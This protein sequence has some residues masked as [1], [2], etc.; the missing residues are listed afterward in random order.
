MQDRARCARKWDL[1]TE[2]IS[3]AEI[4][5]LFAA[6]TNTVPNVF[7]M[8][9]WIYSNPKLLGE[10]RSEVQGIVRREGEEGSEK[11]V[12]SIGALREKCPLLAASF[13]ETLRLVKTG[14]S[15]RTILEDTMLGDQYLLKKGAIVQI[16]TGVLQSDK[17]TWGED[18][19]VFN[20]YRWLES[21]GKAGKEV[22]EE[23]KLQTQA[24]LPFG[25]GKNLCP[26]RH[27]AFNEISAFVAMVVLGFE[28]ERKGG[29]VLSAPQTEGGTCN[30]GDGSTSPKG[31][32]D[33]QIRRRE[34]FEGA[35][36]G[37]DVG[38]VA[39]MGSE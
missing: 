5:I 8:L 2:D 12:L 9:C 15:V 20:P 28:I 39:D 33:I 1:T 16:P 10:L 30:L 13:Q 22:K 37:F 32:V 19:K 25:G 18:S 17:Q 38:S 6:V 35:T 31:D 11:V 34:E 26:G 24:Y 36:F 7:F 14:A 21:K 3:K 4:S 23:R 27:L 29:G